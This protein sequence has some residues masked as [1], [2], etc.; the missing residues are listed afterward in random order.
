MKLSVITIVLNDKINIEKTI[1]SV[2][3]QNIELE[4]IVIDGGSIDGTLE[5]IEKYK[6]K[7]D[8]FIS[9]EDKGIYNAMNKAVKKVTGD[10]VCF[11]NSG[12]IFYNSN[13]LKNILPKLDDNVDVFYGDWEVRYASKSKI[14]KA[15]KS[16]ENICRGMVFS[17]QSCFVRKDILKQYKFN[18]SNH[19]TADYELFYTLHKSNK[20]F[21]Y[22]P[23]IVASVSAGG[24]SDIKRV[25]SIVSR[26]NIVDKSFKVNLYYLKLVIL[27]MIKPYIK[28][29]LSIGK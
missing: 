25:D 17:H 3:A 8:V 14:I 26:W 7:I 1:L 15:D 21:K 6:D 24:L 20:K 12:D 11:M 22:I 29:L 23:I 13:I 4:Y 16:I 28:K 27:E 5:V 2:L 9:E 10:F 19:I 18:E